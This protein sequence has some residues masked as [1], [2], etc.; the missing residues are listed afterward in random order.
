MQTTLAL[1]IQQNLFNSYDLTLSA[2]TIFLTIL[3]QQQQTQNQFITLQGIQV[4]FSSHP[5]QQS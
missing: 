2:I 5:S 3:S 1:V 4:I